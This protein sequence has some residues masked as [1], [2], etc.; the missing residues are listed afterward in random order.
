MGIFF[1][2]TQAAIIAAAVIF[3]YLHIFTVVCTVW[4]SLYP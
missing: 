1:G 4:T 3:V 2:E